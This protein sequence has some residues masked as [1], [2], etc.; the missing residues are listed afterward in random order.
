MKLLNYLYP[1]TL[2]KATF[3]VYAR[4]DCGAETDGFW[5]FRYTTAGM[6]TH[7]R[8]RRGRIRHFLRTKMVWGVRFRSGRGKIGCWTHLLR[9]GFCSRSES[10]PTAYV[11]THLMICVEANFPPAAARVRPAHVWTYLQPVLR[12]PRP[13]I[14]SQPQSASQLNIG[15]QLTSRGQT[16]M[17]SGPCSGLFSQLN[18][19]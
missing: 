4:S 1:D 8:S 11:W 16:W 3:T 19:I 15:T 13:G 2:T 5:H 7:T 6:F 9:S 10:T 17:A 18:F 12:A 14:T